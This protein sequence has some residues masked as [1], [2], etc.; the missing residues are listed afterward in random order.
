MPVDRGSI[1]AQLREIGEGERWWEQREFRDLPHILHA[2]ESIRGIVIGK[3][4]GRRRP[5]VRP[6]GRWMILVTDQRLLCLK[7]ERF[8]RKQVEVPAGQIRA[9]RQRSGLRS[10]QIVVET[11]RSRYRIRIPNDDAFRFAGALA[12][13][14]PDHAAPGLGSELEPWAWIPGMSTVAAMTGVSA[15]F[16]KVSMLSAPEYATRADVERLAATVDRLQHEVERLQQ[17]V[18]FLEEL[19][20]KR[21]EQ[22]YLPS[23]A[24]DS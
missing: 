2:D 18:S 21:A 17:E 7:Q 23:S 20:Q 13:L 24:G 15:V 14:I 4:L 6:T 22:S 10:H 8:A 16:S 12:P 3:L 1:D 11:E 5:R 9:I 19:L